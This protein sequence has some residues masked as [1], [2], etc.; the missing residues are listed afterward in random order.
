MRLRGVAEWRGQG[1]A[2][3]CTGTGTGAAWD[4]PTCARFV[5]DTEGW[6][7]RQG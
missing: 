2:Y 3:I 5:R 1:R 4:G 6:V 7:V